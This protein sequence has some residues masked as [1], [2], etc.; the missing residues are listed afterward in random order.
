MGVSK[1]NSPEL[2]E[3]LDALLHPELKVIDLSLDRMRRYMD[4]IGNP[5]QSLP[6]VIHVAGTN[7]KG[8]T[9]AFMR[10]ALEEAGYSC[11]VY[12]SPHLVGF[13]ERIVL[14]GE[15]V[16]EAKL[17]P[18]LRDII[19]AHDE[20]PLTFFEATTAAA[21]R[22][23]AEV[24]ADVVLLEVGMG[25]QFDATN[26]ITPLASVITPIGMD[27]EAFLGDTLA[28]VAYEKACI[29]KQDVPVVVAPQEVDAMA[30]IEEYARSKNAPLKVAEPY[31][32]SALGLEGAH[33]AI[34][35][36]TAM[37]LLELI[38]QKL[39]VCAESIQRGFARASWPARL[40]PVTLPMPEGW[41]CYVDGGHNPAAALFLAKWMQSQ[42]RPVHI[43][44]A[45]VQGKD[46]AEFLKILLPYAQSV[47]VMDIPDEP[48]GEPAKNLHAIVKDAH[49][50]AYS[51]AS[52]EN[53]FSHISSL[54]NDAIL[55]CCGSLYFAG[56]ILEKFPN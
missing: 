32:H 53:A 3:V 1:P 37:Q 22:L 17:L 40:Q 52:F 23:F 8:S 2:Q 24:P 44:C 18:V 55:L 38:K 6:P 10:A 31:T 15:W 26:I 12:T 45:M 21:F 47:S 35:A 43:L 33:Q 41:A 29:I 42:T 36:G 28:K 39:A 48:L 11:H 20:Y 54:D 34:N 27:H 16:S 56:K 7:G 14:A 13:C 46:H 49:P 5:E 30:V 4:A 9:I 50:H 25:G 19:E 51:A